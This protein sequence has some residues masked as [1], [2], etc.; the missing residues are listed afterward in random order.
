M[1]VSWEVKSQLQFEAIGFSQ[2][3][4]RGRAFLSIGLYP[5]KVPKVRECAML[6]E[7]QVVPHGIY[8]E[9][10]KVIS[11]LTTTY[12]GDHFVLKI[13]RMAKTGLSIFRFQYSGHES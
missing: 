13:N 9:C 4:D 5:W 10:P 7:L 6:E 11:S 2:T 12:N 1:W 8:R 3:K